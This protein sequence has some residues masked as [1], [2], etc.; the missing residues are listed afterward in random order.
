MR[1]R[2]GGGISSSSRNVTEAKW[3]NRVVYLLF[4]VSLRAW[5]SY[6]EVAAADDKAENNMRSREDGVGKWLWGGR[7]RPMGWFPGI[8]GGIGGS[9]GSGFGPGGVGGSIE[10]SIPGLGIGGGISGDISGIGGSGISGVFDGG[11]RLSWD[12][13]WWRRWSWN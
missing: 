12:H 8:G 4:I 2:G 11:G 1:G 10:G 6:T 13:W 5:S 9:I 7:R 3:F